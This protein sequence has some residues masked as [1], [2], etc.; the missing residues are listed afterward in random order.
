M[1]C[2]LS[3]S[4]PSPFPRTYPFRNKSLRRKEKRKSLLKKNGPFP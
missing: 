3:P 2:L 4:L 1:F